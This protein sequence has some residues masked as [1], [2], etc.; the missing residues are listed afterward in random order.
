MVCWG[1][2]CAGGGVD[3]GWWWGAWGKRGRGGTA[4]L[5]IERMEKWG[6][7]PVAPTDLL[8]NSWILFFLSHLA[9]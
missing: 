8:R 3:S 4:N 9:C 5:G 7:R 1:V 6:D 2:Y